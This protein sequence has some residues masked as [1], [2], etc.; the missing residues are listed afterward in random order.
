MHETQKQGSIWS[1]KSEMG[2]GSNLELEPLRTPLNVS[3][4]HILYC[5]DFE[6]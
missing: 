5:I 3:Q 2:I 6:G 1:Y 4:M